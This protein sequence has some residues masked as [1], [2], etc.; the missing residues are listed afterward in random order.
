MNPRRALISIAAVLAL[1]LGLA[2]GGPRLAGRAVNAAP[3]APGVLTVGQT[4]AAQAVQVLLL[5][6]DSADLYFPIMLR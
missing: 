3:R 6:D 5:A 4:A 2:A 1:G